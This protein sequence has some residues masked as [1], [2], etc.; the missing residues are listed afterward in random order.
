MNTLMC[1]IHNC[2]WLAENPLAGF[3]YGTDLRREVDKYVLM[4]AILSSRATLIFSGL[5][6][7]VIYLII[8]YLTTNFYSESKKIR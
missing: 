6:D 4:S 1:F 2:V 8:C 5:S 3:E 7:G